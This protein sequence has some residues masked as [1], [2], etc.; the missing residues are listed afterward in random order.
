MLR[1]LKRRLI[2]GADSYKTA[3]GNSL[4]DEN[5]GTGLYNDRKSLIE[6]IQK[7]RQVLEGLLAE[8]EA[9]EK[10]LLAKREKYERWAA[11]APLWWMGVNKK[12]ALQYNEEKLEDA[13]A[14]A[15]E[16]LADALEQY[17]YHVKEYF[18][19]KARIYTRVLA[20]Q[21][22]DEVAEYTDNL[23]SEIGHIADTLKSLHKNMVEQYNFYRAKEENVLFPNV[24]EGNEI[25]NVY[26]KRGT[27]TTGLDGHSNAIH[28]ALARLYP[29]ANHP[30]LQIMELP[31]LIRRFG[32][33]KVEGILRDYAVSVFEV[34][35]S[36]DVDIIQKIDQLPDNERQH[37]LSQALRAS[38]PWIRLNPAGSAFG[39]TPVPGNNKRLMVGRYFDA[40]MPATYGKFDSRLA[41]NLEPAMA[42]ALNTI[43]SP[44]R[45]RVLICTEL[46]GYPL[47]AYTLISNLKTSYESLLAKGE[48]AQRKGAW[49]HID[50]NEYKFEDLIPM[51]DPAEQAK[52]KRAIKA[53]VLGVV[54]G[55]LDIEVKKGEVNYIF[56]KPKGQFTSET[57]PIELGIETRAKIRLRRE[58]DI[59]KAVEQR[60]AEYKGKV[61]RLQQGQYGDSFDYYYLTLMWYRDNVYP[62]R[63]IPLP[64]AGGGSRE[65]RSFENRI[66]EEEKDER[67]DDKKKELQRYAQTQGTD[68]NDEIAAHTAKMDGMRANPDNFSVPFSQAP[69]RRKVKM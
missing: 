15:R 13:L 4:G 44:D 14:N 10:G 61:M 49:L 58:E 20:L 17:T 54:L 39:F 53:F 3:L 52:I 41:A 19:T 65:Q 23:I 22:C 31:A 8:R 50:H 42:P 18:N 12:A 29:D 11:P 5:A 63:Y 26:Y 45:S 21:V 60:I 16:K 57:E 55:V 62:V 47:C 38:Q 32:Q 56:H 1:E 66:L 30:P 40:S 28:V 34:A 69:D 64:G 46:A 51:F 59:L 7:D 67:E 33:D 9:K 24:F 6:E 25:E 2:T 35:I 43:D 68:V 36:A 37:L 27:I 48:D